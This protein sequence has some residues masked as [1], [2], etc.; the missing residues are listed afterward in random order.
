MRHSSR[1]ILVL[2]ACGAFA[3]GPASLAR[4]AATED[5]RHFSGTWAY[6]AAACRD[7]LRDRIPNEARKRGAGLLIIRPA[8]VEWVTPATCEVMDLRGGP[9]TWQMRGRARSRAAIS[10]PVSR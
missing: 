1:A 3:V 9:G 6:T 5:L 4:A 8:G 2:I 10:R 7:Y